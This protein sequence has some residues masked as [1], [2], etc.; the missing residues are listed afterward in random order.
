MLRRILRSVATF[1]P[2]LIVASTTA[3]VMSCGNS[4]MGPSHAASPTA[5]QQAQIA[6]PAEQPRPAAQDTPPAPGIDVGEA[7]TGEDQQAQVSKPAEQ[8]RPVAQDTPP[9]P[10]IDVAEASAGQEAGTQN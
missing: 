5:D 10:G 6:K 2:A 4:P 3:L 7:S 1:G 9:A 8:P